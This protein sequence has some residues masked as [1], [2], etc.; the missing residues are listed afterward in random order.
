MTAVVHFS[1]SLSFTLSSSIHLCLERDWDSIHQ[2]IWIWNKRVHTHLI[3]CKETRMSSTHKHTH[4]PSSVV[5]WAAVKMVLLYR[6]SGPV[7]IS[8]DSGSKD[9]DCSY[10]ISYRTCAY[11]HTVMYLP[12][13][14]CSRM[15]SCF[16]SSSG[17]R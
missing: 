1:A 4:S 9:N 14:V 17:L 7:I 8:Y 5:S 2:L 15:R 12:V 11:E 3:T 10:C 6:Q 13:S 16:P